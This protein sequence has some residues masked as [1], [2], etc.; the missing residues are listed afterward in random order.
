MI[1]IGNR[2]Y[3]LKSHKV[4]S[5]ILETPISELR[6]LVKEA[7]ANY[8]VFVMKKNGKSRT[9]Q[10]PIPKLKTIH[11][12]LKNILNDL[13]LP[14]YVHSGSRGR[15][16]KGNAQAHI[17]HKYVVTMDIEKFFPSCSEK[18][19]WKFLTTKMNMAPDVARTLAKLCTYN[20]YI[21][22][23]SPISQLLAYLI[24]AEMF[25]SI[26][27]QAQMIGQTFTLYVDDMTFSSNSKKIS[28]TY[29]LYINKIIHRNGL[30]LKKSKVHYFRA[31]SD[32]I[33]TGC[34]LRTNGTLQAT[35]KL[36]K[37]T[38]SNLK[39]KEISSM[40]KAELRSLYGRVNSV[41]FVE[42]DSLSNLKIK[43][44]Q[45]LF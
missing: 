18:L 14:E 5:K 33:I 35:N 6:S 41:R 20:G 3:G 36:K 32:K 30:R 12:K 44:E 9:V 19:I 27:N 17:D 23:G 28:R 2:L 25:D 34:V 26:Y 11:K 42:D 15:S 4:L 24:N 39:T 38:F 40:P 8:N 21:P 31:D 10:N 29:H 45:A 37:K 13:N 1:F 43:V 7:D 22:T 16:Y